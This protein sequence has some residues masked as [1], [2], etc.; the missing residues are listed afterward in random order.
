MGDPPKE[1][2]KWDAANDPAPGETDSAKISQP[3]YRLVHG[4]LKEAWM[5]NN[6]LP[7]CFTFDAISP[8]RRF[9]RGMEYT[10]SDKVD[11]PEYD[12]SESGNVTETDGPDPGYM[13]YLHKVYR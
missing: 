6:S 11:F 9:K 1:G 2:V 13:P 8:A 4:S 5:V 12:A 7:M 3:I 10:D